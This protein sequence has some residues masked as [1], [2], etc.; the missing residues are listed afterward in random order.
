MM[1]GSATLMR[2]AWVVG[3]ALCACTL[4]SSLAVG[5]ETHAT[6]TAPA[7]LTPKAATILGCGDSRV[8]VENLAFQ[9][10]FSS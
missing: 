10:R 9:L 2:R 3:A 8:P 7:A 1:E 6:H 4:L 5:A